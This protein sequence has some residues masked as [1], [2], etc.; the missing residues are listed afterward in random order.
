MTSSTG[1]KASFDD[2]HRSD[3]EED[4]EYFATDLQIHEVTRTLNLRAGSQQ[5]INSRHVEKEMTL[6][7][8]RLS[9]VAIGSDCLIGRE[10]ELSILHDCLV[11]ISYENKN[12]KNKERHVELAL[13]QG[14]SGTGK[15]A[16]AMAL[17]KAI[18]ATP[19]GIMAYGKFGLIAGE[20]PDNSEPYSGLAMAFQD[21]CDKML[22][23][24]RKHLGGARHL[25][26]LDQFC[27]ELRKELGD[28]LYLV[29]HIVPGLESLLFP[30]AN[31]ENKSD[32]ENPSIE[33]INRSTS[34]GTE[35]AETIQNQTRFALQ[36][37]VRVLNAYMAPL[38]IVVDDLQWVDKASLTF[39]EAL[40]NDNELYGIPNKNGERH[41]S[42]GGMM[43]IGCYRSNEVQPGHRLTRTIRKLKA[44]PSSINLFPQSSESNTDALSVIPASSVFM[45]TVITEVEVGYLTLAQ[46]NQLVMTL[47][48][49]DDGEATLQLAKICHKRS[50]GNTFF[51]IEFVTM[52]EREGMLSFNLG[53]MQWRWD[54][55]EIEM[56]TSATNN[57]V[58]LLKSRLR[59]LSTEK[60]HFLKVAAC[61]G[62]QFDQAALALAWDESKP[63]RSANHLLMDACMEGFIEKTT[64]AEYR[65]AHNTILEAVLDSMSASA[66]AQIKST[67]GY[68]LFQK[69]SKKQLELQL[70]VVTNLFNN[71]SP[72]TQEKVRYKLIDLNLRSAEKAKK[73]SAFQNA[74]HYCQTGIALLPED[75][76]IRSFDETL[77]LFS[78]SAEVNLYLG[79]IELMEERCRRII[80]QKKCTI[81]DKLR[82]Y[83]VLMDSHGSSGQM[84]KALDLGF[85]ALG[86]LGYTVP[87]YAC[88]VTALLKLHKLRAHPVSKESIASL[89]KMN[90][91]K[92][93]IMQLLF[94]LQVYLYYLKE[95]SLYTI[96]CIQAVE[97]TMQHGYSEYSPASFASVGIAILGHYGD[98]EVA[99]LFA[100]SALFISEMLPKRQNPTAS[101]ICYTTLMTLAW[102]HPIQSLMKQMQHGYKI[103]MVLGDTESALWCL[104]FSASLNFMASRSLAELVVDCERYV[105]QM[106]ENNRNL[107][108]DFT[109][110]IWQLALNLSGESSNKPLSIEGEAFKFMKELLIRKQAS[111]VS[112]FGR[113]LEFLQMALCTFFGDY[114]HGA[115][116]A[117]ATTVNFLKDLP[118]VINGMTD[119]FYKAI[120]CYHAAQTTRNKP[121]RFRWHANH[122]RSIVHS[123]LKKGNPNVH[124]YSS[125]LDAEHAVLTKDKKGIKVNYETAIV[126]AARSG[127][128]QD[129][130]LAN[131]RYGQYLLRVEKDR[132]GALYCIQE[133]LRFYQDWGAF[134]KEKALREE[135]KDLLGGKR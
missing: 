18:A 13:I 106:E 15:T 12:R 115:E 91:H 93:A 88:A 78:L 92:G 68:A 79:D 123:W 82:A 110:C 108:A 54:L 73:Y 65:W 53:L 114:M 84:Q 121:V 85:D 25:Q 7:K 129:A 131:E 17:T 66:L 27:D 9:E 43:I 51:I 107:Q 61:L 70:F 11:R 101:R 113:Q 59:Q 49:I 72:E 16:L 55:E 133:A 134:T 31:D 128:L 89:N 86:Q 37:F 75:C 8:L 3:D 94:R 22:V 50:L 100:E 99:A 40:S 42:Q 19:R 71:C 112:L 103:G 74:S 116:L 35:N 130:A 2:S 63:Y 14:K 125:F 83:N 118:V 52:L 109:K 39:I 104:A 87:K 47:L 117:L 105:N 33:N 44:K 98:F 41:P 29:T 67:I 81:V 97:W 135:F 132:S 5:T 4:G 127:F 21:L 24:Q 64:P 57:V 119:I 77:R 20:N 26:Y 76:W 56:K 111:K 69:L 96:T 58:D 10:R 62:S 102:R 48:A 6:N 80:Q 28:R 126:N 46:A 120:C 23:I 34:R 90:D 95:A 32:I 122:F 30:D 1:L 36:T 45:I 124:H 38:V 60:I